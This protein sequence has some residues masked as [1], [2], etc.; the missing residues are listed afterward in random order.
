MDTC[1]EHG[2]SRWE[3]A[4]LFFTYWEFSMTGYV[5]DRIASGALSRNLMIAT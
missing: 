2:L 5:S 3:Q 4:F 1:T